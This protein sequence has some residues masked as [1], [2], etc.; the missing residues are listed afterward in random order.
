MITLITISIITITVVVK[1]HRTRSHIA[2]HVYGNQHHLIMLLMA[3]GGILRDWD[4]S[5]VYNKWK[6]GTM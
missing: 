4:K 1:H 6:T 3:A 2:S 5:W